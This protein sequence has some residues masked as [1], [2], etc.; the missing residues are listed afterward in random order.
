[1]GQM[2]Q[3]LGA[4]MILAAFIAAQVRALN[5][6]SVAYLLLNFLGSAVLA[7]LALR[8]RQWGFLLLEGSWAAVSLGSLVAQMRS[9][10]RTGPD[11]Q[12]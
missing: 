11:R 3:I 2:L 6:Q 12:T 9:G 8:E 10:S 5:P 7:V 1:M 4:V